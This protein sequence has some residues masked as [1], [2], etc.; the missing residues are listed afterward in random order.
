[1]E[2]STSVSS[3]AALRRRQQSITSCME[4]RPA[5]GWHLL[6]PH[7]R[8]SHILV[9]LK[10]GPYILGALYTGHPTYL[11][12]T[13]QHPYTWC[14]VL[15]PVKNKDGDSCS[16]SKTKWPNCRIYNE[17]CYECT[18]IKPCKKC[19]FIWRMQNSTLDLFKREK[20][21][22]MRIFDALSQKCPCICIHENWQ[23][24]SFLSFYPI[25]NQQHC[26]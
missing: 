18:T 14:C 11:A 17:P 4:T 8:G 16:G 20:Q 23:K 5:Y 13:A 21:E 6:C 15:G 12:T 10:L 7:P 24:L 22:S 25:S 19:I 2:I 3:Q 1:M 26:R 9:P